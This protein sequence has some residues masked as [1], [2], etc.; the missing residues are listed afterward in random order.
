MQGLK[1]DGIK[2]VIVSDDRAATRLVLTQ[3]GDDEFYVELPSENVAGCLWMIVKAVEIARQPGTVTATTAVAVAV[4]LDQ[5]GEVLL[6]LEN[7][8]GA[9]MTYGMSI[10]LV[11]QLSALLDAALQARSGSRRSH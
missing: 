9:Q 4:D 10:D 1:T 5:A 7:T 3:D 6:T 8:A 11:T 2:E